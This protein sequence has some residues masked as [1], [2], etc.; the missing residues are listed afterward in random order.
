MFDI[1]QKT[2]DEIY[3]LAYEG[4]TEEYIAEEFDLPLEQVSEILNES[5]DTSSDETS[6][7][8]AMI[9]QLQQELQ[10]VHKNLDNCTVE[11]VQLKQQIQ[12]LQ[13]KGAKMSDSNQ[14]IQTQQAAQ[15]WEYKRG[16]FSDNELNKLGEEGW[17]VISDYNGCLRLK[18]PKQQQ[19]APQRNDYYGYGR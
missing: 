15:Q 13:Q 12:V 3:K 16:S 6:S 5:E 14:P 8:K 7:L 2:I 17:E 18:R 9:Q 4:F 19:K 11:N 1:P 10:K